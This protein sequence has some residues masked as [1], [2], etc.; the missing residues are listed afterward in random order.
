MFGAVTRQKWN[1][2]KIIININLNC[3]IIDPVI[4]DLK[5]K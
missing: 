2:S 4:T 3:F 1:L 5:I